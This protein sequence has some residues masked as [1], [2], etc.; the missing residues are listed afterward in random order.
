MNRSP[1]AL[2][3]DE[4]LKTQR[5]RRVAGRALFIGKQNGLAISFPEPAADHFAF[6]PLPASRSQIS[7]ASFSFS[8]ASSS[9]RLFGYE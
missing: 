5:T 3:K 1:R 4:Q 8:I 2:P 7:F 6:F 9:F